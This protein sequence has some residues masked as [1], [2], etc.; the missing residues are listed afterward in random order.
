VR[1]QLGFDKIRI[2]KD[3]EERSEALKEKLDLV[4]FNASLENP[5]AAVPVRR[6]LI[7]EVNKRRREEKEKSTKMSV[8]SHLGLKPTGG[9]KSLA[10]GKRSPPSYRHVSLDDDSEDSG[11]EVWIDAETLTVIPH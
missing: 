5:L 7:E 1:V 9:E 2:E 11:S 3:G 8:C 4:S 10:V 6:Y